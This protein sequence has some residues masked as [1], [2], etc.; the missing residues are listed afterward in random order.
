MRHLMLHRGLVLLA[1]FILS[2]HTIFPHVHAP[3]GNETTTVVFSEASAE[4]RSLLDVLYDLVTA[5]LGEE[6]LENFTPANSD[7]T[8]VVLA[9]PPAYLPPATPLFSGN[10]LTENQNKTREVIPP[11]L[12]LPDEVDLVRQCPLRG[13]PAVG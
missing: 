11:H 13:P 3:D 4:A 9:L 5:D 10:L 12:L 8:T 1:G 6:H 7:G 2:L